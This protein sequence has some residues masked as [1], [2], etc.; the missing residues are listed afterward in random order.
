MKSGDRDDDLE[1]ELVDT[2][3]RGTR[4][5]ELRPPR[6]R[7]EMLLVVVAIAVVAGV[8]MVGDSGNGDA[9]A[10]PNTTTSRL[11]SA[12]AGGGMRPGL[13]VVRST[14]TTLRRSRS[15]TTAGPTTIASWPQVEAGTGPS[16]PGALTGS[17]VGLITAQGQVVVVDL[18]TG[19][20]C[21]TAE[22]RNGL[23]APWSFPT[24]GRMFVQ[25]G[26]EMITIDA[27]CAVTELS[28][29]SSES[30]AAA[31]TD[32]SIWLMQGGSD[33]RLVEI[34][35]AT[36]APTGREV[37][38][39]RYQD[40]RAVALGDDVVIGVS[41]QMTR[42]DPDTEERTD[43]GVGTPLAS[44]GTRLALVECPELRCRLAVLDTSTGDRV[45]LDGIEPVAWELAQFSL[46]GRHLRIAVP[47]NDRNEPSTAIVDI[48]TGE[49]RELGITLYSSSFTP[50]SQWLLGLENGRA[51]A[52]KVD[53]TVPNVEIAPDLRSVENVAVL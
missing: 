25:T 26:E 36:G 13:D 7:R 15:T 2:P 12:D 18:D 31:W 49:L 11:R 39:P 35:L 44:I 8:G 22:F 4:T 20:Q 19:D 9:T 28:F 53:G 50:D 41:G 27:Q 40:A 52:V 17:K 51:I 37:A 33:Q 29:N 5:V 16:L 10:P 14:S 3:D 48:E 38:I 23:Y 47:T 42:V 45:A 21:R 24:A 6:R 46:D 32:H 43:L 34:D 1:V 30:W